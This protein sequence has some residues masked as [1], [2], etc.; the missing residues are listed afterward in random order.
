M[1]VLIA[2]CGKVGSSLA[3]WLCE[4]GHNVTVM[5]CQANKL[6][7]IVN[8]HD[9]MGLEGDATS[10]AALIEA[11]VKEADILCAITGS[12]EKNLLSCLIARQLSPNCRLIARV[13]NPIYNN[14]IGL[15]QKSFDLAMVINPEYAAAAEISRMFRFPSAININTFAKGRVELLKF[16]V[17]AS[18]ILCGMKLADFRGVFNHQDVLICIAENGDKV[19]I[20]SGD[21]VINEGDKLSVVIQPEAASEF[22]SKA[23]V[24]SNP[25]KSVMVVGGGTI[26]YYLASILKKAGIQVKIIEQKRSRC[27]ELDDELQG[28]DIICGDGSDELLLSEEGIDKVGGFASLTGFDE[29]NIL[30]SLYADSRTKVG[31]KI[32]TKINRLTFD[33]VIAN[34]NLGSIINPKT[35][36]AE[37]CLQY[38]RSIDSSASSVENFYRLGDGRVEALEFVIK[39]ESGITGKR[40]MDL[41]IRPHTLIAKI[42]RQGQL[43]TPSGQTMM[44]VGDS[45]VVIGRTR[46]KIKKLDDILQV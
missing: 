35:L 41:K 39:E 20:P 1:N 32:V 25:V 14:E 21:Y 38:I 15:F 29:E 2:G 24:L 43:I 28:V 17:P 6:E 12:D 31:A 26:T 36:T 42:F 5:D 23:G 3:A 11:G 9:V 46:D 19:T 10:A 45:V 27:E 37:Y 4:D 44:Q 30:L 22:F 18:S 33:K 13:R 8:S 16:K 34:M 7:D 40:I